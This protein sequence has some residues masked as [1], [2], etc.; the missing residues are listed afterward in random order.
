MLGSGNSSW[1][2]KMNELE[3]KYPWHNKT[4]KLYWRGGCK[5]YRKKLVKKTFTTMFKQHLDIRPSGF[6]GKDVYELV[7]QELAPQE[8]SMQYKAVVD[9]DGTSWSERFPRLLCYNSAVVVVSVPEDYEEYFTVDLIPGV[10]FIPADME[11]FTYVAQMIMKPEQDEM[12]RGVVANANKWC[13]EHM[14]LERL[15]LDF[16]SVLNGYVEMLNRHDS[17]WVDEW[18]RVAALYAN[19]TQASEAGPNVLVESSIQFPTSSTWNLESY[20]IP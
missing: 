8:E 3:E 16:L 1:Q 7:A 20:T 11:N 19:S 5:F 12:L 4:A 9:I 13:R 14:V 6:C 15:N 17:R 2:E 10:H 18:T